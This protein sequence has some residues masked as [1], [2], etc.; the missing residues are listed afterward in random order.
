MHCKNIAGFESCGAVNIVGVLG[1]SKGVV[2]K[3]LCSLLE[4][5]SLTPNCFDVSICFAYSILAFF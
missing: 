4:R 1:A 3:S 2:L 5:L